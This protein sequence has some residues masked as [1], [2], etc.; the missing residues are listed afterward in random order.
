MERKPISP[1]KFIAVVIVLAA[2]SLLLLASRASEAALDRRQVL[3]VR[4]VD[5]SGSPAAGARVMINDRPAGIVD[6]FGEF[7]AEVRVPSGKD[8]LFV[9]E[10]HV[11][12]R[13]VRAEKLWTPGR[14]GATMR[15][16][17]TLGRRTQ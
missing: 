3:L 2:S 15:F 9:A 7:R 6:S 4:V 5:Q 13:A 1:E 8:A 11:D 16:G 17:M 12:G 14:D 10:K